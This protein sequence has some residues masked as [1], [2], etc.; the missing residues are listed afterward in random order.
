MLNNLS[1]CASF[2][3]FAVDDEGREG[4]D[5]RGGDRATPQVKT[6]PTAEDDHR[7]RVKSHESGKRENS[8]K[9]FNL[10]QW[11]SITAVQLN[12]RVSQ[13]IGK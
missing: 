7:T 9:I 11:W 8:I 10:K 3:R 12:K 6:N 13:I 1:T 4:G 5:T 2:R